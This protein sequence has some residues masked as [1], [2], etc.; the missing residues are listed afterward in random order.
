METVAILAGKAALL[1]HTI[2]LAAAT[3][4]VPWW[5]NNEEGPPHTA[6]L[7]IGIGGAAAVVLAVVL[8]S[9]I[10][11]RRKLKAISVLPDDPFAVEAMNAAARLFCQLE[12]VWASHGELAVDGPI[13]F[14]YVGLSAPSGQP[15]P[16]AVV[17]VTGRLEPRTKA[18]AVLPRQ[19]RTFL[20]IAGAILA[21]SFIGLALAP[22]TKIPH[23]RLPPAAR[24]GISAGSK[25][26]AGTTK[27]R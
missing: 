17:R 22:P 5:Q 6:A 21:A 1:A 16:R 27:S 18:S 2:V 15:D 14:R 23:R 24:T 12:P 10:H 13:S 3:K 4:T 8:A 11:R 9:R 25:P 19:R 7:W 20:G 26:G